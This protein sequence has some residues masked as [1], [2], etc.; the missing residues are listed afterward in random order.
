MNYID[1][2]S[3]TVTLPTDEMRRAMFEAQVGDDVYQDDPTINKLEAL[4]AKMVGKEAAMFVPS[5]T[6]G[7]Q[8][9]IMT[10]LRERG[11]EIIVSDECHVVAH[12]V[13][14]AAV[15]S[16]AFARTLHYENG[17][18][19]PEKIRAAVR[20][21]NIHFPKT[22]LI[23]LENPLASGKVVPLSVM[24]E[25]RKIA[26][27]KNIPIHMDG[28]RLF[29]AATAL[30]VEASEIV[31]Y[32]DSVMFCL[33]KGLC[34]P[35]GSMVAGSAEFIER[36]R[37]NRKL[38]GGGMRQAGFLAAAGII[39]LEKMTKRLDVDHANAKYMAKKLSE[40][41]G[42]SIDLDSVE[43]NMVFFK[44]DRPQELKDALPELMLKHGIKINGERTACSVSLPRTVSA[45]RISTR[46][47]KY[48]I[49]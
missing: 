9:S 7:N 33:S 15:L 48:L 8:V 32:V 1:L 30:G 20:G 34:A 5:G 28:A 17:I 11:N 16:Q 4:A 37:K 10:H 47:W 49:P 46:H 45:K 36:A 41:D 18:P 12:E 3:D 24:A 21:E 31:K 35:V 26:D 39:A 2:R 38:L 44:L 25:V 19:E 23:C 14:A 43:I 13:G 42:I 6:M 22:G 29:N 40:M 27:E